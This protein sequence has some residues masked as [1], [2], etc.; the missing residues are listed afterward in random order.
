MFSWFY[1]GKQW[2]KFRENYLLQSDMICE[3]CGK[4]IVKKY[5]AILHHIIPLTEE[6]IHDVNIAYNPDNIMLVHHRCHNEIHE[7]FGSYSRHVYLVYG[8]PCSGKTSYVK[9]CAG[10]NDIVVDMDSIY[11]MISTNDRY[12]KPKTLSSTAFAMRDCLLDIIKVRRGRWNN[13][14]II[15][16]YPRVGERQ[17]LCQMYGAEEVFV[18]ATKEECLMRSESRDGWSEFI[19]RWFDEFSETPPTPPI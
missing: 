13:A 4:P 9:Q 12:I 3:H 16:G 15:G 5:D 18:P 14:Y 8:A 7:R 11:Q 17:R 2:E 6:N 1:T 19:E 10:V